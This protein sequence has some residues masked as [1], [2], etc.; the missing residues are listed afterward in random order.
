MRTRAHASVVADH[1]HLAET[2]QG[3]ISQSIHIFPLAH[4]AEHAVHAFWSGC[5]GCF[6]CCG[7]ICGRRCCLAKRRK[8]I[9][10][11]SF[12]HICQHHRHAF[13]QEP[14]SHGVADARCPSSHDCDS[15]S[16][17][18]H[19]FAVPF[20]LYGAL[21]GLLLDFAGEVVVA[22]MHERDDPFAGHSANDLSALESLPLASGDGYHAANRQ[23]GYRVERGLTK[24]EFAIH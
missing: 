1:M 20:C 15:A 17:L 21:R 16:K 7:T 3:G 18:F 12:F 24:H 13:S 22:L 8:G 6:G 4:I 11:G 14:L 2:I 10:E 9:L 23:V 5:W 19:G